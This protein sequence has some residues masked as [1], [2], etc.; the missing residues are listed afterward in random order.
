MCSSHRDG[1]STHRVSPFG[2]LRIFACLRLPV[3]FRSLPRPS[4]ALGAWASALCSC[5]LD[6]LL[7]RYVSIPPI[8]RPISFVER[9][10][11]MNPSLLLKEA[12]ASFATGLTNLII[13]SLSIKA[14]ASPCGLASVS[15]HCC[16][17]T[18][19]LLCIGHFLVFRCA[20]VKVLAKLIRLQVRDLDKI[21][22][23]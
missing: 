6:L 17:L 13:Y 21:H 20:V 14:A 23:F 8:L 11:L 9:F 5:S 12:F 18:S 16:L 19:H 15:R 10:L 3:A 7:R 1:S 4:S 2:C 22:T